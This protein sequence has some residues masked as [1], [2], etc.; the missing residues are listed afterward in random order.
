ML[1]GTAVSLEVEGQLVVISMHHAKDLGF[2]LKDLWEGS[3]QADSVQRPIKDKAQEGGLPGR[4]ATVHL[5][6]QGP[7]V[8]LG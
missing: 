6:S 4:F 3:G 7:V 5:D 2:L 8:E 1:I